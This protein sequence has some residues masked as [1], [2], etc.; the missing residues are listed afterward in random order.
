MAL[1]IITSYGEIKIVNII[2]V[3][4]HEYRPTDQQL[5]SFENRSPQFRSSVWLGH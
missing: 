5:K 4:F 1:T 3:P 2:I